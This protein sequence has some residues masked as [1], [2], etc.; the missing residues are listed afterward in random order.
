MKVINFIICLGLGLS[1]Q[2]QSGHEKPKQE[3]TFTGIAQGGLLA[4]QSDLN[5][6]VQAIPAVQKGNWLLGIGAGIDNYVLPGISVVAHGQYTWGKRTSKLFGYAQAGPHFPWLKN[7]WDEKVNGQPVYEIKTGWLGE[8]GI[9]YS[10][11]LGKCLKLLPSLGYSIKQVQYSEMQR[12]WWG[13]W[14][15]NMDPV[16]Y[17]NNLT[18]RRV[19]LKVGIGF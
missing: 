9:G 15:V 12:F 10:I 16:F 5:Y 4:G 7:G 6:M 17:E 11:P 19:V 2:A 8:A 1:L 3:W 13:P 14:P 18:M